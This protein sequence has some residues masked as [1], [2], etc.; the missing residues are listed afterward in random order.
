MYSDVTSPHQAG[1]AMTLSAE[2]FGQIVK[3]LRSDAGSERDKRSAPRVGLRVQVDILLQPG[4]G[5][6]AERMG[7]RN[8]SASGIGLLHSREVPL[9][10]EFVARLRASGAVD[11]VHISC[12]VVHCVRAAPD[13]FSIGA[14][15]VRVLSSDE[16][17]LLGASSAA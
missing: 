11:P 7:C 9:G 4:S 17:A 6:P 14:R 8:L 16:A 5:R 10:T 3:A 15:V 1:T 2:L 13:L 12:V